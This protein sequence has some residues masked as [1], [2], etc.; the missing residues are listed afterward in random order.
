MASKLKSILEQIHHRSLWQVLVAY[1]VGSWALLG[2]VGTLMDVLGLPDWVP[3]VVAVILVAALPLVLLTTY[4]QKRGIGGPE[5]VTG[6]PEKGLRRWFRWRNVSLAFGV[7]FALL[8]SGT[9]GYQGM[10]IMGIGS[11]GTLI[12]KGMIQEQARVLVADLAS[13]PD[14]SLIA[15]VV[16]EGLRVDL[17]QSTMVRVVDPQE[18]RGTLAAMD[19]PPATGLTE[20]VARDLA[21]REGIPLLLM[22]NLTPV[23]QAYQIVVRLIDPDSGTV[24][25]ADSETASSEEDILGSG[26]HPGAIER[27]VGRLMERIG[28]PLRSI[29]NRTP[30]P[31][32]TTSSLDALKLYVRGSHASDFE[33]NRAKAVELTEEALELDST[34]A[35]AWRKLAVIHGEVGANPQRTM[36]A[37]TKAYQLS[38]RLPERERLM[39][40][41]SYYSDVEGD[42]ERAIAAQERLVELDPERGLN[43]LAYYY[44]V[45]GQYDRAV[46]TM[47]ELMEISVGNTTSENFIQEA[48]IVG[49]LDA[50][51]WGLELRAEHLPDHPNNPACEA[52]VAYA[53]GD[54]TEAR[55]IY[56]S[57]LEASEDRQSQRLYRWW[58]QCLDVLEGRPSAWEGRNDLLLRAQAEYYIRLRPDRARSLIEEA[59]EGEDYEDYLPL[60]RLYLGDAFYWALAGRIETA[61]SLLRE[62]DAVMPEGIQKREEPSLLSVRGWLAMAQGRM[63][64][65][66][67]DLRQA[68]AAGH[69]IPALAGD[70]PRAYDLA[71]MPDSA[72]AAYHRYLDA[73]NWGRLG[74]AGYADALFLART[75]ERLGQL[76][77]ERGELEDAAKYHALF[78]DLWSDADPELQPRVQA[79]RQA[80]DRIRGQGIDG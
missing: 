30:L 9:A 34:F 15:M 19:L 12:A 63:A 27:L 70:L 33:D 36:E 21:V 69:D 35:E 26:G 6:A 78:V 31:L 55:R 79:A 60:N 56:E 29:R 61:D 41:A 23:V 77:E 44:R 40:E 4:I 54:L 16:S 53:S 51:R 39:I 46:S 13:P 73:P 80:L 25:L 5:L 66:L 1:A 10:R 7:A 58:M 74:R 59:L 8:A 37:L 11:V 2:G 48:I 67:D 75:Y 49:D 32:V 43:N 14:D 47:R 62:W 22:G 24:L 68:V 72:L 28:E 3:P 57:A 52:E 76:H 50:A 20:Q 64:D 71:G 38:D 42:R 18:V 65:G 17:R 45:T